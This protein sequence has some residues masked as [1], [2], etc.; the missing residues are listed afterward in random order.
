MFVTELSNKQFKIKN[1]TP[2]TIESKQ[3][4]QNKKPPK[5]IKPMQKALLY[6]PWDFPGQNTGVGSGPLLQDKS[7]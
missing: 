1:T 4:N 5:R 6:S 2:F 3:A 7:Q